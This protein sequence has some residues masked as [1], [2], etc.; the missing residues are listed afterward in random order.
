MQANERSLAEALNSLSEYA[1]HPTKTECFESTVEALDAALEVAEENQQEVIHKAIGIA[2]KV[3]GLYRSAK[4]SLSP[5]AQ[6]CM[7]LYQLFTDIISPFIYPFKYSRPKLDDMHCQLGTQLHKFSGTLLL[8]FETHPQ[9]W[10]MH[11]LCFHD[12]DLQIEFV[13]KFQRP[14]A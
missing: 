8:Y 5:Q 3:C 13:R 4:L 12:L 14:L 7:S 1:Q 6:Y 2:K 10:Y 11:L 9:S